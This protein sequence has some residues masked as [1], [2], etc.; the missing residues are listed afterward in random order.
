MGNALAVYPIGSSDVRTKC[1]SERG[2]LGEVGW[3]N[4]LRDWP[5]TPGPVQE[6]APRGL[7]ENHVPDTVTPMRTKH[8]KLSDR[9]REAVRGGGKSRYQISKETGIDEATLSRFVHGKGGLSM[10]GIDA[11]AE[12]L[13]L[14]LTPTEQPRAKKGG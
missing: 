9:L 11:V 7:T 13:G 14:E 1:E 5:S 2:D 4:I 12:C 10:E 8:A 6:A 3:A